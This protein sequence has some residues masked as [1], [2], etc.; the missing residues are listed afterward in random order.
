MEPRV[1]VVSL[2]APYSVNFDPPV[3]KSSSNATTPPG[4][5][6]GIN[7]VHERQMSRSGSTGRNHIWSGRRSSVHRTHTT[8]LGH[9]GQ[10]HSRRRSTFSINLAP[11]SRENGN[12]CVASSDVSGPSPSLGTC[13]EDTKG[14]KKA[15]AVTSAATATAS[16]T[17]CNG[18]AGAYQL[19]YNIDEAAGA[20]TPPPNTLD[21][22]RKQNMDLLREKRER[23]TGVSKNGRL[24]RDHRLLPVTAAPSSAD[25]IASPGSAAS[26]ANVDSALPADSAKQQEQQKQKQQDILSYSLTGL[27]INTYQPEAGQESLSGTTTPGAVATVPGT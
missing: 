8:P 3:S 23:K 7:K 17:L 2:F 19:A 10:P 6:D 5:H 11:L 14:N 4:T 22:T 24:L 1:L 13:A 9:S 18:K 26:N 21:F 12:E 20:H 15:P 16:N 25:V 27:Q